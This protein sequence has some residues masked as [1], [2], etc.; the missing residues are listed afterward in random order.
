MGSAVQ[1]AEVAEE[2][3][4]DRLLGPKVAE[5]VELAVSVGQPNLFESTDVHEA[6]IRTG[7]Y[8]RE[9][10]PIPFW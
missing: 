2:H 1:S 9:I 4:D 6:T 5:A 3:H 7:S 8:P 10:V